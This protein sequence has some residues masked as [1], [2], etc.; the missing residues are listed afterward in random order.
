MRLQAW[1]SPNATA[2]LAAVTEAVNLCAG[3]ESTD[4]IGITTATEIVETP[5]LG[6]ESISW[7]T[8]QIPPAET[9]DEKF[10]ALGRTTVARFGD[11]VMVLQIGDFNT[12]GT[13]EL[14]DDDE[15]WAIVEAAGAKLEPI[16][17]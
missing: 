10:E 12:T 11:V 17:G 13:T 16:A 9:Q 7:T 15:W 4:E 2:Y 1:S 3:V 5:T 8:R 14:M 6:D